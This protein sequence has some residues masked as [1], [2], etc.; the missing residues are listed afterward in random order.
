MQQFTMNNNGIG[1]QFGFTTE[2]NEKKRVKTRGVYMRK[3]RKM[4]ITE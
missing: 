4:N 2:Y 3:S 1:I